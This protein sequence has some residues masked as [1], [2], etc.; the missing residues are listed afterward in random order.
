ML[1]VRPVLYKVFV[2]TE[3]LFFCLIKQF[4]NAFTGSPR[5]TLLLDAKV[6]AVKLYYW[7]TFA[8]PDFCFELVT[9]W[10]E[11][12]KGTGI[13]TKVSKGWKNASDCLAEYNYGGAQVAQQGGAYGGGGGGGGGGG[14][15]GYG[16]YSSGPQEAPQQAGYSQVRRVRNYLKSIGI[17]DSRT[18]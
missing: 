16:N 5:E 7:W 1:N 10:I 15:G 4:N 12:C 14:S 8:F 13:V 6:L 18:Y 9:N 2:T 11:V 17:V 3:F